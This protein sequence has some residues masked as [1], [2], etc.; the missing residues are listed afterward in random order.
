[1]V[2]TNTLTVV[3]KNNQEI[4]VQ[5]ICH[6]TERI[7]IEAYLELMLDEKDVI[8][9]VKNV[10]SKIAYNFDAKAY[11]IV[12]GIEL[13]GILND[14]YVYQILSTH[15]NVCRFYGKTQFDAQIF[16]FENLYGEVMF[17]E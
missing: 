11:D 7:V 9:S 16:V 3:G 15:K 14:E 2:A 10:V 8:P 12:Y 4:T 1:M 13:L 5:N 17:D 6:D